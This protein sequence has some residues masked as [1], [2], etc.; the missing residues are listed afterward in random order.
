MSEVSTE[1]DPGPYLEENKAEHQTPGAMVHDARTRLGY[2]LE[3]LAHETRLFKS[4]LHQL[5]VDDY[6]GLPQPA[7][8]AGYYRQ[9]ARAMRMD[10]DKLMAAFRDTVGTSAGLS[11]RQAFG[12]LAVAPI[13]VTP[14]GPRR[15]PR[16]LLII[17][18]VIALAVAG[19]V[20]LLPSVSLSG[21]GGSGSDGGHNLSRPINQ[22]S[23]NNSKSSASTAD[24][25]SVGSSA[26]ESQSSSARQMTASNAGQAPKGTSQS[27]KNGTVTDSGPTTPSVSETSKHK[28]SSEKAGNQ[29]Q[30]GQPQSG[31]DNAVKGGRKVASIFGNPGSS[32]AAARA[33]QRAR[34]QKSQAKDTQSSTPPN[35][36]KLKFKKKSWVRVTNANGNRL[37]EGIF[38]AGQTRVFNG[39]PPYHVVLG[40]A[41]GVNIMIGGKHYSVPGNTHQGVAH[42]TIPARSQKSSNE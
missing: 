7:L 16:L 10:E 21:S 11:S 12:P 15:L 35:R 6:A 38:K 18:L 24:V 25:S 37:Y 26:A 34:A 36:L 4:T 8:A 31:A 17:V 27:N 28:A 33:Q 29:D 22:S 23:S 39:T 20:V 32:V 9:C 5:E 14:T 3:D 30:S 13:D 40:Y 2:T 19:V 42:L 41:P 1:S